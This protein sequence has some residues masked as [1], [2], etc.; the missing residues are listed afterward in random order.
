MKQFT[1]KPNILLPELSAETLPNGIRYYTT[2]DNNVY[3]SI[4]TCLGILSEDAIKNWQNRIGIEKANTITEHAAERGTALHNILEAFLKNEPLIFPEDPNSRVRVMFNRM[5]RILLSKVDNILAQEV[6]LYSDSLGVAGRCDCIAEFN[7]I[8][9]IIDFK[10]AIK[11]KKED[12]I[13]S[14]FLQT[15]AYSLMLEERTGIIADQIVILISGED[16][17][18]CQTFIKTRTP[19]IEQLKETIKLFK[20]KDNIQ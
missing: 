15:T 5:K 10:S 11:L 17:F 3:P 14:Y 2:P 13:T 4:T 12:W 20:A 8:L 9:S 6:P 18:S 7:G 16:D 19:Y 1:H